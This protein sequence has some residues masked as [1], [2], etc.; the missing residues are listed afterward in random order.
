MDR[1]GL[2]YVGTGNALFNGSEFEAYVPKQS[3]GVL[4]SFGLP[5]EDKVSRLGDAK[6]GIGT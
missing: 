5:G 4:Y 3:I 6:Q 2:V 1:P